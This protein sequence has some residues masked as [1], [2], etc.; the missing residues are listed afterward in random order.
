MPHAPWVMSMRWCDLL[1][2]H[3]PV[4]PSVI[5]PWLP[6]GLKL[7]TFAGNAWLGVV[8]F[9]MEA[10][11]MRLAPPVPTTSAFPEL[12]VRTYVTD[13]QKPGVWF[14]SLDA[15]SQ[16][17]VRAARAGF[18]LPY[19]DARMSC[20]TKVDIVTYTSERTHQGAPA[21]QFSANYRPTGEP[22]VAPP[23]SLDDWLTA[24]YCLY[25]ANRRGDL[26]RG[27]IQHKPWPLQHASA[28]IF[29][30]TM[31]EQIRLLTPKTE[32]HLRFAKAI[33]VVAWAPTRVRGGR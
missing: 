17:A 20:A 14:F 16:L 29:T 11:R 18:H 12:N 33:D 9:R 10:V 28:N 31:T 6:P 1:F 2:I 22:F 8:P 24:R 13:G 32:P 23:G 3:W 25:A 30:N 7:E 27:E 5:E 26:W 21:A 4:H 19:F 15:T